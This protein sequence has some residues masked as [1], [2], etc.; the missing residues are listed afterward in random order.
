MSELIFKPIPPVCV[1]A[2]PDQVFPV[3]RV[4]CVG[5]N[6]AAHV[7]E[8][9][10][11]PEREAPCF[12]TKPADAVSM[13]AQIPYP[14]R[15]ADLHHEVELVVALGKGGRDIPV[16]QALDHVWGYGVGVDLT[17][18]DLQA[19]AKRAG[20]PWDVAKGFDHSAPV[21]ALV[22]ASGIGHP[23][24]GH[25]R[26]SVNGALRQSADL[27]DMIWSVPE[28]IAELS[29]FYQLA[30]G[31]LIFTGTPEG[32]GPLQPGDRVSCAIG[33]WA[34]LGFSICDQAM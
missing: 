4:Y 6:Y 7:R 30:Q 9:G 12:F 1:K 24:S 8:M 14:P 34:K 28:V 19:S 26:L 22:A 27:A 11:Q 3:H 29:T 25:I 10:G 2:G 23:Q 20:R 15:T 32:V 5:R 33:D 18:R 13:A 16:D 31:D 21:S 17:R